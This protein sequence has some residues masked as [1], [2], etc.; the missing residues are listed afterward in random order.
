MFP[1]DNGSTESQQLQ[2]L[3]V[4]YV[5]RGHKIEDLM[6]ELSVYKDSSERQIRML[7]HKLT[8]LQ[9]RYRACGVDG[10]GW[11]RSV[12]VHKKWV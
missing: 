1:V 10:V 5:A 6:G 4:L 12:V 7:Q 2:Q 3:Q 8:M 9:G 11:R